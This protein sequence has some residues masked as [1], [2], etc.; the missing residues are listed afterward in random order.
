MYKLKQSNLILTAGPTVQ[1]NFQLLTN[2]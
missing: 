2:M 1:S